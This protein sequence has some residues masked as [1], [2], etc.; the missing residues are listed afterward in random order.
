MLYEVITDKLRRED[1][2]LLRERHEERFGIVTA[3]VGGPVVF[4]YEMV[5]HVF[6]R[7]AFLV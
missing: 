7:F 5:R 6:G 3:D 1:A 4:P 2:H